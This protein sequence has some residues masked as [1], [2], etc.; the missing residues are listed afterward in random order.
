MSLKPQLAGCCPHPRQEPDNP[1]HIF[2]LIGTCNETNRKCIKLMGQKL[3]KKSA[4]ASLVDS[5]FAILGNRSTY[6]GVSP[7]TRQVKCR[8]SHTPTELAIEFDSRDAG[9]GGQEFTLQLNRRLTAGPIENCM[10]RIVRIMGFGA[11]AEGA[12]PTKVS[13]PFS[14]YAAMHHKHT[15]HPQ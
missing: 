2:E 12:L 10:R 1:F 7:D 9:R 3:R 14:Q 15:L 13:P 6:K 4:Q 8:R 5:S 11:R